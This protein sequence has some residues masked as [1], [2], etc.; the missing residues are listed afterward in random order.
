MTKPGPGHNNPPSPF[1]EIGQEINDLYG[2]A[3]L[4]LDGAEVESQ[5]VADGLGNLLAMLR[6][7]EKR[8]D[9]ARKVEKQPHMDAG[10]AVDELYKP[11]LDRAK[12]A[13]DAIKKA[14]EKWLKKVAA[15]QEAAREQA[16]R[17]AEEK[18]R[19]AQEA[20]RTANPENLADREAA[21]ALAEDAKKA[22]RIAVKAEKQTAKA[23]GALGKAMHLR[24]YYIAEIADMQAFARHVWINESTAL[25]DFLAGLA[26]RLVDRNPHVAIPGVV[27]K[28]DRRVA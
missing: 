2:E 25:H 21:E 22:E 17:E 7:A 24:T 14:S 1:E 4:W 3:K 10:K 16:R 6:K 20:F 9:D 26:Q 23:G 12:R 8:A 15:E 5:E 28:E 13:T 11:L 18:A 27:V 19:A